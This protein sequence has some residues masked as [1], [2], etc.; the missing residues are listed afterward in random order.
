L[1]L[2]DLQLWTEVASALEIPNLD[3]DAGLFIAL[4][5]KGQI[6]GIL[7]MPVDIGASGGMITNLEKWWVSARGCVDPAAFSTPTNSLVK[8]DY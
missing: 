3:A 7:A 4:V 6:F 2:N 8:D 5:R 1:Q